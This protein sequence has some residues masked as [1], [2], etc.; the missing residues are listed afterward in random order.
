MGRC[1]RPDNISSHGY[2]LSKSQHKK[3]PEKKGCGIF[4]SK[5]GWTP[6]RILVKPECLQ[7]IR[8]A[9][10]TRAATAHQ[11]EEGYICPH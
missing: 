8:A 3:L 9:D 1:C 5:Q 11:S 6:P 4:L 10:Y 7:A 2:L